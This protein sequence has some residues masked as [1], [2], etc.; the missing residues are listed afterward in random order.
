MSERLSSYP[1]IYALGHRLIADLFDGPVTVEEKIDGSQFSMA[2]V[3]G[4]L[5]CRSK[6]QQ[7]V[8]GAPEKMFLP[9]V[10]SAVNLDLRDGWVYRCEYLKSPKHNTLAYSR[11]PANHLILFDVMTSYETYLTPLEKAQEA[12]RLGLEVVPVFV[13]HAEICVDYIRPMLDRE[14][15]LGGCKIEGIVVK[16]YARFSIDKKIL[17][18]KFVSQEFKE[19]HQKAWK[20]SNPGPADVTQHIISELATEARY[21]KAVQHLNEAGKLSG[22]P[23][24]IGPLLAELSSDLEREEADSIKEALFKHF[25]PQIRRG[26]SGGFPS[27][28]KKS[29]GILE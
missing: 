10:T 6:G 24:D 1:S 20:V 11:I 15:V 27:W 13:S 4:E 21:K 19:R 18:G 3:N 28:Y 14:S 17:I 22:T 9:A 16:N 7:I 23:T 25:F 29:I 8:V 12:A 2:R 26:V 5:V